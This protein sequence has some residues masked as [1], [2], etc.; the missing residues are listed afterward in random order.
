MIRIA[1]L[2]ALLLAGVGCGGDPCA[3]SRCPND[4]K[5]SASEY[6]SCVDR[7]NA[8]RNKKCYQESVN[9]ELCTQSAVVCDS[10]GRTDVF[11]SLRNQNSQCAN[12]QKAVLCCAS[13]FFCN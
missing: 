8:D 12:T 3:G 2:A 1:L 11:A 7:H 9:H 5:Q 4:A 10:N 6:Q 13:T